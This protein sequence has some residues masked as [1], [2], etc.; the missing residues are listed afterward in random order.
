MESDQVQTILDVCMFVGGKN[1]KK[2]TNL[3]HWKF[4]Q[5]QKHEIY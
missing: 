2:S 1:N 5:R 3:K 4:Y